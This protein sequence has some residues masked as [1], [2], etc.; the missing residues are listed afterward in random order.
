MGTAMVAR[1]EIRLLIIQTG[2]NEILYL[3]EKA[4]IIRIWAIVL[5]TII[6]PVSVGILLKKAGTR[7]TEDPRWGI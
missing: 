4:F 6:S 1:G 7:I 3:S 5:N 2:L